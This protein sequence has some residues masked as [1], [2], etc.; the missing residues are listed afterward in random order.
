MFTTFSAVDSRSDGGRR[1]VPATSSLHAALNGTCRALHR[2]FAQSQL[3]PVD[4]YVIQ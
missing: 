2:W 4:N 3:G 1:N